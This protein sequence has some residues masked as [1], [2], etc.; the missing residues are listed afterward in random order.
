MNG[1]HSF[2]IALFLTALT[3]PSVTYAE[4][5]V[6]QL[7]AAE[8]RAGWELLFDGKSTN[9][10][11]NYQK[12]EISDGWQV[13][14][15]AL[16]RVSLGAGDIVS[17]DQYE[18]FELSLEYRI[19]KEGNSGVMF[20]VTED[21]KRPY[22]SGPEVQ[23]QDNIDGHDPEKSGWLYQLYKPT[24]PGW[25]LAYQEEMKKSAPEVLDATRPAGQW[26]HLYLRVA[27]QGEVVVNGIHYFYFEKGSDDWNQRVA[28]SKF[29]AME[30]FGKS[31]R[32]YICLQDHGNLVGYR[33]IKVRRLSA[34]GYDKEPVDGTLALKGVPAFPHLK[35]DGWAS[36]EETG[37]YRPTRPL[38]VTHGNDGSNRLFVAMQSG[39]IHTV[40]NDSQT[41]SSQL[42]LDLS[43]KVMDWHDGF[44]ENEEGLLGMALHPDYKTNG[45]LF[46][47]YTARAKPRRSVISRF[48]VSASDPQK[49]DPDSEE[50]LL[51]IPQPFPNHN[52]GSL[53][54][55][56]DGYLYVGM[57]D[58]GL[59]NDYLGL[60]QD[61]TS[62]HGSILRIDVDRRQNDKA[63]GIP[64]D[65][66][67]AGHATARPEIYAYG[68]RNVWRLGFD[69]E[70][71]TLWAGD[72]GQ[73]FWEEINIVRSGGNYGW[74]AHEGTKPFGNSDLRM[75]SPPIDP[76]WEY[77][78]QLGKSITGGVVYRGSLLPELKGHYLYA[79]FVTGRIWA[80]HYDEQSGKAKNL[81]IP[82]NGALVLA[83]GEDEQGE[84]YYVTESVTG[85]SI[86]RFERTHGEGKT[87]TP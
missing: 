60:A 18:H 50:I 9:G 13:R 12:E 38:S 55:G 87:S 1:I 32:G 5:I 8:R 43:K 69:R 56:P 81:A 19:S 35:W 4:P 27:K 29:A 41:K 7:S 73:E 67:F 51:E 85:Q 39:A 45:Q 58:G 24:N 59:R 57:G 37:K 10:W 76:I 6:N 17:K 30:Q 22:Y 20:H 14:D 49:A 25:Q 79:D 42:Y 34:D 3:L 68:F 40:K 26:N 46:V 83:F 48:R 63:Y 65:N 54:F 16:T 62:L 11:R 31:P 74:S 72:V 2:A 70:T 82:S 78:H 66:P 84:V 64:K 23:V 21:L 75:L 77:D 80:L 71:G 52:G 33:N 44:V 53:A 28:N 47:Y 15:A 36:A 61:L 86:H